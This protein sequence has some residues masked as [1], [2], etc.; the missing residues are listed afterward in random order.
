M[1]LKFLP[2]VMADIV[3][4]ALIPLFLIPFYGDALLN[5]SVQG[6]SVL[7][8]V[9]L[10]VAFGVNQIKRLEPQS[11]TL[12][13]WFEKLNFT[14]NQQLMMGIALSLA[15]VFV[16][17]QVN[18]NNLWGDTVDLFENTGE[19]HEGE[20]TLYITF[21]PIFIWFMAGAFYLIGFSLPTE[22]VIESDTG[23]YWVTE[24]VVL[25][26]IN[27][28]L[29]MFA[30]FLAGWFGRFF[31][32]FGPIIKFLLVWVTLEILFIPLRLRHVFKNPSWVSIV[33][34]LLF[35]L[36]TVTFIV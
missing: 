1:N 2:A 22:K 25:L 26:L 11:S 7:F 36:G 8:V 29:G 31:P 6:G 9:F 24:F 27:I 3:G 32:N 18:L 30:L 17:A 21:G 10:L 12:P 16:L 19:V 35:I 34:F 20:M 28:L 5:T 13:K 23:R 15:V 14:H 33:S 4:I